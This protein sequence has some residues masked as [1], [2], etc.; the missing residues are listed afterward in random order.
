MFAC[1][2]HR[3]VAWGRGSTRGMWPA[4]AQLL[5][6]NGAGQI[7]KTLNSLLLGS[8]G[9]LTTFVRMYGE[10]RE[11]GV[12]KKKNQL[13]D[14]WLRMRAPI[15]DTTNSTLNRSQP[16]GRD[17][18]CSAYTH[19]AAFNVAKWPCALGS[20]DDGGRMT[21]SLRQANEVAVWRA[22]CKY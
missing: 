14:V 20:R 5:S 8:A 18:P 15:T 17:S 16:R 21:C 9:T 22:I 7:G 13:A 4:T 3:Q 6:N 19:Q 11:E 1:H 12:W 10:P 2:G